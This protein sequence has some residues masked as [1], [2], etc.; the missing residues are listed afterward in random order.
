MSNSPWV[1]NWDGFAKRESI[2]S[3]YLSLLV[4]SNFYSSASLSD[5]PKPSPATGLHRSPNPRRQPFTSSNL[6]P[7][8]LAPHRRLPFACL[9]RIK[10]VPLPLF[11]SS[12]PSSR[13]HALQAR[14][15]TSSSISVYGYSYTFEA[16]RTRT[17]TYTYTYTHTLSLSP[18]I[19]KDVPLPTH[20]LL[21]R[22][23]GRLRVPL[24]RSP[25]HRHLLARRRGAGP[26]RAQRLP[27]VHRDDCMYTPPRG[28]VLALHSYYIPVVL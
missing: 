10:P 1:R 6:S 24:R 19:S 27:L 22:A 18:H 2:A 11:S 13:Y 15:P 28:L 9:P 21:L 4:R 16:Y 17:H 5:N 14:S 25:L 7:L 26:A 23:R 8:S 12:T 20:H 3:T